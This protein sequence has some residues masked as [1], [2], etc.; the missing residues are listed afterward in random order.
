MNLNINAI[1]DQTI[2]VGLIENPC[3]DRLID[4]AE[5]V[6]ADLAIVEL[7]SFK[8]RSTGHLV[9]GSQRGNGAPVHAFDPWEEGEQVSDDYLASAP[10]VREYREPSTR[11][12][13]EA[14]MIL[15]GCAEFV[16]VHQSTGVDGAKNWDGPKVGLLWHDALHDYDSV[17]ADLKAWLP[18]MAKDA[19]IIL[20]DTDDVRYAVLEAAEAALT[21]TKTLREK[22]DWQGR[23]IVPWAKNEGKRPEQRRRGF[24]VIR[25]R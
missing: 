16:T 8:G 25:T 9:L 20:H 18:H 21:R 7:G 1:T 10:T 2:A 11:E 6:P 15:T 24:A 14:H 22:W 13:F 23:E 4:E 19:T 17:L 5:Q 3:R 12:A